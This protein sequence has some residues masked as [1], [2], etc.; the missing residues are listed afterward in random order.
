MALGYLQRFLLRLRRFDNSKAAN[1]NI[2][3]LS[4]SQALKAIDSYRHELLRDY[5]AGRITAF[6]C[7][8]FLNDY[9]RDSIHIVDEVDC[10]ERH[11]R[12]V[13]ESACYLEVAPD[14][15]EVE[16]CMAH[17]IRQR[18][19][20]TIT[21]AWLHGSFDRLTQHLPPD[22]REHWQDTFRQLCDHFSVR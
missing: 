3:G 22:R 13:I 20:G 6:Q 9:I 2:R 16:Q 17:L 11:Q 1:A 8:I 18:R 21:S 19:A 10:I 4:R 14:E 15:T 12:D 5:R 7:R